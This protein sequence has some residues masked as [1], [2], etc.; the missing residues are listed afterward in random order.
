[1]SN[2]IKRDLK[3]TYAETYGNNMFDFP[4]YVSIQHVICE[5]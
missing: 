2:R 4:V 3:S 1:M 5:S